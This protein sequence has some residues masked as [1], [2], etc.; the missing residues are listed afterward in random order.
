MPRV[1]A[2]YA[3]GVAWQRLFDLLEPGFDLFL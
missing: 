2:H 3:G 1:F